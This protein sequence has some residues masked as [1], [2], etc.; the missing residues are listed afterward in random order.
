MSTAAKLQSESDMVIYVSE[1]EMA[2]AALDIKV[3][4]TTIRRKS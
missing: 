2:F 4:T 1:L 3:K